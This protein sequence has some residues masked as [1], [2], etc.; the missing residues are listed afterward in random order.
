MGWVLGSSSDRIL[1][2]L[3]KSMAIIEFDLHGRILRTNTNFCELMGYTSAEIVGREHSMF[4]DPAYAGSSEYAAFWAKLRRGE[5]EC[6][7]F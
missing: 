5:F 4:V 7:E 2:A 3:D 6:D 1:A